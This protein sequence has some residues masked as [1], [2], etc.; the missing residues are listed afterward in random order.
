MFS[1]LFTNA[2]RVAGFAARVS[3]GVSSPLFHPPIE[4]STFT[5]FA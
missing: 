3:K 1:V 5:P 4:I 2:D